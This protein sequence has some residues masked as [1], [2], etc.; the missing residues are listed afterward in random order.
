MSFLV[1]TDVVAEIRRR[2]PSAR[3]VATGNDELF[4]SVVV[5]GAVRR[6]VER[7]R[8]RDPAQAAIL[9]R[10]LHELYVGY[11]ERIIPIDVEIADEWG[12]I[13][14]ASPIPPEDGLMAATAK[15]RS[16]S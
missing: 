3:V 13:G 8:G 11:A 12:R 1:D 4:I 2:R 16:S 6:G 5:L 10:W 9:E 15:V 7:L 14:A